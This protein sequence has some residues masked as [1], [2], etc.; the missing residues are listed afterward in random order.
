MKIV[1]LMLLGLFGA[2]S[3][4]KADPFVVFHFS[5]NGYNVG[6]PMPITV[7]NDGYNGRYYYRQ[8]VTQAYPNAY[9]YFRPDTYSYMYYRGHQCRCYYSRN[10]HRYV[11]EEQRW[12]MLEN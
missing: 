3:S 10:G 1:L 9:G 7:L 12:I 5:I 2:S 8:S 6:R 4:L 11:Q